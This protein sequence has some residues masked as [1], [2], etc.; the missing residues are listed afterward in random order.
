MILEA[1]AHSPFAQD[2]LVVS[3]E[4]DAWDG[5]DHVDAHR[6]IA[7]FAGPYVRQRAVVSTRYTTVNVLKTVED[8]LGIGPIGLNDALAEPMAEVFDPNVTTWS[9]KAVVPDVLRTTQLPLPAAD[10]AR[11]AN[12]TH[13]ATYW[14]KVMAGQDFSGPDR[15]EPGSFN[16]ALWRGLKGNAP[17]PA[18]T[19]APRRAG[20]E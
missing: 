16:R 12:P 14:M 10:H 9:Y 4:D 2:T 19:K 6:T 8:I 20:L 11:S 1:V 18:E 5:W 15:I 17:Y 13:S 3:I 7:L